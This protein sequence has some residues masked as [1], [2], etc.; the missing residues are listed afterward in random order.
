MSVKQSLEKRLIKLGKNNSP[1]YVAMGIATAKGIFRPMFTM[2]DKK[3]NY[4]TKKYTAL[5][6]GLT[7]IIAIP[8]YYFSGVVSKKISEKLAV[9]K[10][11]MPK[12]IYEKS[13]S[14]NMSKE[15]KSTVEHAKKLAEINFPKICTTTTFIGVCLSAVFVIPCLCSLTIK[16]IIKRLDK[17]DDKNITPLHANPVKKVN[18]S[19]PFNN[20]HNYSNSS[21]MKV[22]GL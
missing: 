18:K 2:M 22:G 9:P 6:E 21:G 17:N 14:G 15:V 10:H 8:V 12:D 4:E 5:R 7:E 20:L 13:K 16:P 1:T 3:E 11:F 19:K